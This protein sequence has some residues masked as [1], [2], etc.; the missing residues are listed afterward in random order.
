VPLGDLFSWEDDMEIEIVQ[1]S[2][3]RMV[4]IDKKRNGPEENYRAIFESIGDG[5]YEVDLKGFLRSFNGPFRRLLGYSEDELQG[6]NLRELSDDES[7]RKGFE[8]FKKVYA[9]GAPSTGFVW[10]M[11]GKD[12]TKR[13]LEISMSLITDKKG[14]KTGFRGIARDVTKR[15]QDEKAW[16]K[17][18]E[19]AEAANQ[20]KS[21]FL[22][23]MSHE[24]R[25]PMNGIIGMTDLTLGTNLNEEQREYL[26]MVK[27]SANSLLGLLNDIL[28]LAKIESHKIDL[29]KIDFDLRTTLEHAAQT[30]MTKAAEAGLDLIYRIDPEVPTAL[31]GD[32]SRLRQ[33]LVNLMGN[34][35]KFTPKGKVTVEIKTEKEEDSLLL[36]HFSVSDTGIGIPSEKLDTV[37][38]SFRQAD[39]SISRN[40]QGTGLG[41]SI[42]KELV[43]L[44]GGKMWVESDLGKGSTFH[45]TACF[46]LSDK[47]ETTT[48]TLKEQDL[49]GLRVLIF[50]NNATSRL[51]FHEMMSSWGLQPTEVTDEKLALTELER[52]HSAG[53]PYQLLVLD[54]EMLESD[55]FEVAAKIRED[56]RYSDLEIILIT[57]LGMKGDAERCKKIGI[58]GYFVKPVK[59]SELLAGIMLVA[60]RPLA[61]KETIITR[62]TVEDARRRLKIL[63]AEDNIVNQKLAAKMLENRGHHVH[64]ASDGQKAIDALTRERYD[65]VLMDIQM[66]EMDGLEATER[67]RDREEQE[68]IHTPIVA[69][70]AHAMKGDRERC[71]AAGMD[72]YLSKPIKAADLYDVIDRW[73]KRIRS[74]AEG[75]ASFCS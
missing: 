56:P 69:M 53:Q 30:V 17:A 23:S 19:E 21:M 63:L 47:D 64:V 62:H 75:R 1:T 61:Q 54:L 15:R 41:L 8:K 40:Y 44:M 32:P 6:M 9:T 24:I 26:T 66:P 57:S 16:K 39:G 48:F 49:S 4:A 55:G 20:A 51:I 28:D 72:D 60:D 35:V 7:A 50:D 37:F 18:K 67:I 14:G 2:L 45:F 71:V 68:G 10:E 13:L 58:N 25:T 33:I 22:A 43:G 11:T 59:E 27:T 12:S 29:E 74:V 65:L 38:E 52:A 5:Y 34:A 3:D 42:S 73:G 70:T 36:L 31:I 46:E